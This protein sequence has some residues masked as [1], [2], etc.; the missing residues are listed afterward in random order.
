[1]SNPTISWQAPEF[2]HY[3][4]N[5]GWYITL[6]SVAVLLIFFFIIVERDIFAAVCLFVLTGLIV[7]FSRQTPKLV[8]VE[9][10]STGVKFGN[11][12]Y[13]YKQIKYFWVVNNQNHKTVNFHTSAM[14]NNVLILELEGQNPDTVR[15]FLL[16]Q[17][18]E[19]HETEETTAQR[20]MHRFK[21]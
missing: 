18:P 17:L 20:F 6:I 15:N 19:H 10:N 8:N 5:S 16:R 7:L 12:H 13:P 4:K 9:L 11:L 1:M 14:V 2:R 21:F 3:P